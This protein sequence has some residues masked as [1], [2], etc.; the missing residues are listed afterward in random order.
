[1]TGD[2]VDHVLDEWLE[3]RERGEAPPPEEVI[4][5]HPEHAEELRV[6]FGALQAFDTAAI[7]EEDLFQVPGELA[8]YLVGARIGCGAMGVVY[9]AEQKG[10][11]RSVALKLLAPWISRSE[12]VLAR[13]E[14][15]A[16][17]ASSLEHEGIVSIFDV[18]RDGGFLFHAMELVRGPSLERVF[19]QWRADGPVGPGHYREIAGIFARVAD[20][21]HFAH[22]NGVIHRDV[23]PSNI[24]IPEEGPPKLTDFGLARLVDTKDTLTEDGRVLGT[25]QYMSPEQALGKRDEGGERSDVYALG[26]TLY[27]A[28]TLRPPFEG[29]RPT[30]LLIRIASETPDVPR[31]VAREIPR[32]LETITIKAMARRPAD[33][34]ASAS[35]LADD[36]RR[37]IDGARIRGRRPW[38]TRPVVRLVR[39]PVVWGGLAAVV[40]ALVLGFLLINGGSRAHP[41]SPVALRPSE[42]DPRCLEI[43]HDSGRTQMTRPLGARVVA[44]DFLEGE[45]GEV[46][47]VLVGLAVPGEMRGDVIR[48]DR[49]RRG[50]WREAWRAR[51][52]T[53]ASFPD[54]RS[55]RFGVRTLR[56]GDFLPDR[57]G[58]EVVVIS[59][60]SFWP[61]L[62]SV[63]GDD[64][65]ILGSLSH[66]GVIEDF[67]FLPEAGRLVAWAC[68]NGTL[69]G[70]GTFLHPEKSTYERVFF[71][72]APEVITGRIED[73]GLPPS[74]RDAADWYR[75]MAPKGHLIHGV[76]R[77]FTPKPPDAE[78]MVEL[79]G[80][81]VPVDKDGNVVGTP[82]KGDNVAWPQ[83]RLVGMDEIGTI[84]ITT[85]EFGLPVVTVDGTPYY[86]AGV[87]E[88]REGNPLPFRLRLPEGTY[89]LA[90]ESEE[91]KDSRR[92]TVAAGETVTIDLR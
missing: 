45:D 7:A 8:G 15:E 33:R 55:I 40:A 89:D 48:L 5:E 49:D 63:I 84:L 75:W 61:S 83:P 47:A 78:I 73:G 18:G 13:F 46:R 39:Q 53:G 54:G 3:L 22:E 76:H 68:N 30:E 51:P 59:V 35:A 92:I 71:R 77:D 38:S 60:S 90:I 14:R 52:G 67:L 16:Q 66:H 12:E 86:W 70:Y 17:A 21:L 69:G 25:L 28:L 10:T 58:Q 2:E 42:V 64:G 72:I 6:L 9:E 29:D 85:P 41:G 20:A 19:E 23:K 79:H 26:A 31:S 57:P 87:R 44:H 24:L 65:E 27:E 34:Y 32:D 81:I 56:C 37:F 82:A 88:D 62:L 36:L 43:L 1:M 91:R 74:V 80:W 11:G 50:G 4:G